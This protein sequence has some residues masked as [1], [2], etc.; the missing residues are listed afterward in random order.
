M[1]DLRFEIWR[2]QGADFQDEVTGG[3]RPEKSARLL[4]R[5]L[6]SSCFAS[7]KPRKIFR[8][9]RCEIFARD[10]ADFRESIVRDEEIPRMVQRLSLRARQG[11]RVVFRR[12][13]EVG[14]VGLHE[15]AI[16]WEALENFALRRFPLV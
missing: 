2:G 8:D 16:R 9:R 6:R 13:R 4:R 10:A 7:E 3:V 15:E 1:S 14:R 5:R 12:R 11:T